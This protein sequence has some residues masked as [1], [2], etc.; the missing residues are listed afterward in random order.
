MHLKTQIA[1]DVVEIAVAQAKIF[2]KDF[3]WCIPASEALAAALREAGHE[4]TVMRCSHLLARAP[5]AHE[6]WIRLR[7]QF[8]WV[9]YVVKVGDHAIDLTRRQFFPGADKPHFQDWDDLL[10]EW[11]GV[12]ERIDWTKEAAA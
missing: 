9:H 12:S 4:A 10:E 5:E 1:A 3:N 11:D 2:K 7:S 6:K 8:Y